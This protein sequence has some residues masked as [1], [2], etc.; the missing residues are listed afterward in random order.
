[1]KRVSCN[2]KKRRPVMENGENK[3]RLLVIDDE[4]NMR[5]MLSAMLKKAGYDV[6]TA[7]DGHEGLMKIDKT[8]YAF[9]L[10]DIKMPNMNGIDFLK[11]ARNKTV[12]ATDSYGKQLNEDQQKGILSC[13]QSKI[14]IITN[15]PNLEILLL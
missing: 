2:F 7:S 6:D 10:C 3:K 15:P 4:E 12:S 14:T 5:H 1:M 13:L 11:A 8:V 9:I